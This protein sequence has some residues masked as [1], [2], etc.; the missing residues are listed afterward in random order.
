MKQFSSDNGPHSEGGANPGYFESAGGLRGQKRD[1]Y[2][3]GIRVPLIVYW[4]DHTAKGKT[5]GHATASWDF[6]PTVCDLIGAEA[7]AG[8]DGISIVPELLDQGNQTKHESLYWE[9]HAQGGKQAVVS[10]KWK[11]LRLDVKSGSP[12][13]ELYN[14]ET[15]PAE[16]INLADKEPAKR[17][18]LIKVMDTEHVADPIFRFPGDK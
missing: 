3:G 9:F 16:S 4:K 5:S 6:F 11:L 12:R 17:D 1:L 14:L 18:E 2:E 10:G 13:L 7:P 8:L 15:D